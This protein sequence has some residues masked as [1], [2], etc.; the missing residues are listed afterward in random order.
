MAIWKISTKRKFNSGTVKFD[1]GM[2]IDYV[3]NSNSTSPS[4]VWSNKNDRHAIAEQFVS[5]YGLECPVEKFE[6][7]VNNALFDFELIRK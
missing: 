6:Q 2:E 7:L 5:K 1:S 3:F 4:S